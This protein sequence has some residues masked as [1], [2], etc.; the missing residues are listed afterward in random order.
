M[1]IRKL[2]A[3]S[4][5]SIASKFTNALIQFFSLPLLLSV[6]GKS[7][8]GL[9][10]IA[11][12]LNTFIAIIQIGLPTGLPKFV[13][14]WLKLGNFNQL[15]RSVRTAFTFYLVIALISFS[16]IIFLSF[17]GSDI[18]HVNPKQVSTLQVLLLITAITSFFSIPATVLDHLLTGCSRDSFLILI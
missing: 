18:F 10:V 7:D 8:Y 15:Y 17:F 14:E 13:S 1:G 3:N 6:Y 16:I 2:F 12:S 11:M 5:F 4:L 9:I